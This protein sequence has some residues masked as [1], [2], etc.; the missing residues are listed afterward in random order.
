MKKGKRFLSLLMAFIMS[1]GVFSG[2]TT[3]VFAATQEMEIY[4]LA[5]PRASDSSNTAD[6]GHPDL[7]LIGGWRTGESDGPKFVYC[8]N[9]YPGRAVYCIE[10]GVPVTTGDKFDGFDETFWNNYPSDLNPTI[11]PNIIKAYIGRVLQYGWEGNGNLNWDS[12]NPTHADQISHYIAT[13][14]LIWETVVGERDSQF[15]KVDATAQGKDNVKDYIL[16]SHPLYDEIFAH[17]RDMEQK[18]KKHTQLP[19]F[20]TRSSGDADTFELK[21]NGTDYSTTLKDENGVLG[22]YEFSSNVSGMQFEV[23]GNELTIRCTTVPKGAITVQADKV[24]GER[25]GVVVWS[26]G[27]IGGGNQDFTTYGTTVSDPVSGYLKLEVMTGNMH[28][29]KTSEDGKVDGISFTISGEGYNEIKKTDANG[30]IDITDMNPG[31]YTVTEQSID[32]YEPQAVQRVTIV[33]GQTATVTFNN[34]LKRGDLKVTK[35]S[36]DGLTEGMTFHLYGTSLSGLPVDEYAVTDSSGVAVF[37]DVLISGSTPFILEEVDTPVR[38]VVPESENVTIHWNEVTNQSVHNILKKFRVTVTKSDSETGEAQGDASLAGATYGIYKGDTL[39]DSYTTDANGS[40]VTKYYVCDT[41]WSVREINPSEGYWLDPTIYPVGADPKDYEI[42]LN[43]TAVD[44]LETIKKGDIALIK[45]TDDGETGIETPE[46]GAEFQ[47]Y[48]KSAGSFD[49]AVETE[50]DTITC[51]ENG[52]AQSKKMPYGIYTVHQTKGWEGREL[53][54]DFDVFISQDSQTYHYI[55]NNR[56][57]A[58]YIKIVKVDAETGNTIPYAGAG[59][60]LFRPDGTQITQTFTYPEVTVIDTFYTTADGMLITPEKLE[61]GTGYSLVEVEA[62][63]G[64]VLNEEPVY[65]D[66]TEENSS[67]ENGFTIIQVEKPNMAQK[68]IIKVSKTGEVFSGVTESDGIYQPV[69]TVQGL[70]DAVYT[71]TAKED[72][73]TL[74]GTLRYSA[75]EVVDTIETDETGSAV[76]KELYLGKFLVTETQ[77]PFGMVLSEENVHEI[78]L[79]Y[80]GQEVS[81]TETGT[82]FY[83]ERQ[84]ALVSIQK[85][86]EQDELFGLGMNGEISSVTFGLY[87]A[88]DIVAA[89]G[90]VIPADGLMEI[91][92]VSEDGLAVCKTDLP[93]GNFYLKELSVDGNYIL[94]SETKYPFS[95]SYGGQDIAIIEIQANDGQAVENILK[96][97]EIK[98]LKVDE[99]GNGLAGAVIGLFRPDCEEFTAENALMTT[100]SLEDGSFSFS[101]VPCNDFIVREIAQPTGFV[102]C[103]ESFPVTVTE[104]GQVIEIQITNEFIRGNLSLTKYDADF[105]ENKLS[106]AEFEVYRDTNDNQQ[107]DDED[108]LLGMMEE[109]LAGVYEMKDVL[110]GGVLVKEKTAPEG[111][112]LEENAYYVMIDTDGKTYEIENEAGKGFTNQAQKGS[113]KIIKTSSDGVKEGFEFKVEGPNGYERTFTTDASGEIIIEDLRVGKY[114][115]TELKNG[116]SENYEIA[117]PV[118]VEIVADE[119]LTVKVHN[120]K[121]TVDV[122][123]TGDESNLAAWIALL[124]VGGIGLLTTAV[125]TIR[126]RRKKASK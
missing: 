54:D 69:Y 123:K 14:L 34:V 110:Y 121:I 17:Y 86:L 19:S 78:E 112:V 84:K 24:G 11:S 90:A 87:A 99:D 96:R 115:V 21:W 65:F 26:D 100:E 95:F 55:L 92:S 98:G 119:M 82:D 52:F 40:F 107:L 74:D 38:Y 75:G 88:E 60:Q 45:H 39:V 97:G 36:E 83:N 103:E 85:I 56:N 68:G 58:S 31:V 28:L 51:D 72:V 113:L 105:P 77:A 49:A 126:K 10:P 66:V 4:L 50:R 46:T 71:I 27:V 48:L 114:V 35:T 91:V 109:T 47:I 6:W 62:P 125:I 73:Y 94:D 124:G 20:F 59:F 32:K 15:N 63:Y 61:Y 44:A 9:S 29:V 106:G 2:L 120:E 122:P 43:D 3:N 70:P 111:F 13:Q 23:N 22:N 102:L 93:F 64:Y 89:D 101:S 8:Q 67:E 1:L 12:S 116:V 117:D 41:D 25:K 80:A 33:S 79:V 16:P 37:E 5:M 76:S 7:H 42:E 81:V 30:V 104:D 118:T 18:V 57:F 53:I 108:E